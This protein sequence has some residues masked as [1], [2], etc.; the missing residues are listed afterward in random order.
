MLIFMP[1]FRRSACASGAPDG[2][3]GAAAREDLVGTAHD[4]AATSARQPHASAQGR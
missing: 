3:P 4:V 2:V 1:D